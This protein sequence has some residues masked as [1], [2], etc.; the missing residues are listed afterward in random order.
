MQTDLVMAEAALTYVME[1]A[2]V[3]ALRLDAHQRVVAANAHV[4][5]IL[6]PDV[7]GS[8]LKELV[9]DFTNVPDNPGNSVHLLT[10]NTAA[11]LPESFYFRRFTLPEGSLALGSLDFSEQ[12]RLR[13][14]VL[15]LNRELND[16]TRQLHLA[17]AELAELNQLKNRFLGMAAHDLRKPVGIIMAYG[18]FVLD[19]A[20]E[21]LSAQHRE[22]LRTCLA[23]A[24]SMKLLIDN[25]LDL[26]VIES[27]KLR[28]D[29]APTSVAEILVGV[30]PIIRLLAQKKK[31]TL[32]LD[33]APRAATTVGGR[34]QTPASDP[35]SRWQCRGALGSRP[36]GLVVLPLGR[37]EPRLC[38][39][40]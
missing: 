10:L 11:G 8:L 18:E 40:R 33:A 5:R 4:R 19:E 20:G 34:F 29:L 14:E 39:A 6:G 28:L 26:S 31:M 30:E 16:L 37:S 2:P 38:G 35:E 13:T 24:N 7:V 3:L 36:A 17:N 22:Y 27:G 32:L 21:Q 9:V 1:T 23:A 15:G 25:F 12:E